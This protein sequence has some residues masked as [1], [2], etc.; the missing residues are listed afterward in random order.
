MLPGG[1]EA[2]TEVVV[3]VAMPVLNGGQ[4]LALAVQSILDQ[5]FASWELLIVD[6]GSTDGSLDALGGLDDRVLVLRD[7]QN[8][9]LSARLNQAVHLARGR[10]FARMD[11]DDVSHPDRLRLQF[12]F[13]ERHPEIDLLG[14]RCVAMSEDE[15]LIGELPAPTSHEQICM[16]PWKGF[17]LAHPTWIARTEWFAR[18]PYRDPGP[19]RCEDQELLLRTH[20]TSRFG[21]LPDALLAY[22]V[23]R[24]PGFKTLLKTRFALAREQVRYFSRRGRFAWCMLALSAALARIGADLVAL[25]TLRAWSHRGV[26]IRGA[27]QAEW[28]TIIADTRQ[29]ADISGRKL[30]KP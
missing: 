9:G 10:Y 26:T 18:N 3:T 27:A 4:D 2:P 24:R 23:R 20:E 6:D 22:R 12:E 5:S 14:S 8:R 7:S 19:Y 30:R 17:Y 28:Q 1:S 15:H 16:R 11:H 13:L 21:A 25:L 29:R